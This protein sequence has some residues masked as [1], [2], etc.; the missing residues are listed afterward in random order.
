[1]YDAVANALTATVGTTGAGLGTFALD[2]GTG[3]AIR[4]VANWYA[5]DTDSV[6]VA[7][8]GGSFTIALGAAQDDVTHI[9]DLPDRAEL[10]SLTGD[11]SDLTFSIVGQGHVLI[12]LK[13]PTGLTVS[14]AGA[15]S[16]TLTG[17]KLDLAFNGLGQHDVVV[18]LVPAG[19]TLT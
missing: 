3:S 15:D 4:S 5:Y 9:I 6:F 10:L 7:R 11:G 16:F 1:S 13:Q 17:D 14:V 2:L 19:V 12:D 8:A 18:N